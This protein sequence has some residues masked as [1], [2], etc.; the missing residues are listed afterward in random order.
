M[1]GGDAVI[2][3]L[4]KEGVNYITGFSG[5]GR[6]PL[7]PALRASET[8]LAFSTRHERLGV[9]IAD[10][11]ARA[12]GKVGVAMTG[13]GPGATNILTGIAGCYADNVPVLLLM[14]QHPLGSMGREIQQ[15]VPSSIFDSLVKWKGTMVSV[16]QIPDIMRRA[17]TTLRSGSPGPV[18]LEMPQDILATEA[19]D[20]LLR[21][22]PI[23]PGRKAAAD[24]QDI[25][26][27]ADILVRASYPIMNVG[28][29]VLWADA[30]EEVK[31]LGRVHSK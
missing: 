30:S 21:Y 17:F 19:P 10:G 12:T 22:E 11:Y 20:E 14:G 15:E 29:G 24:R 1:R 28:G 13:T 18:V 8:I 16:E 5:G 7:W 2:Q 9:D 3:A 27:A 4:E 31:E 25:D 6:T 23:G 26:K